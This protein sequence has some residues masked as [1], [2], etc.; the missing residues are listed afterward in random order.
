MPTKDEQ[1]RRSGFR[2]VPS[3]SMSSSFSLIDVF[4]FLFCSRFRAF[5]FFLS[6][7]RSLL[8]VRPFVVIRISLPFSLLFP[9]FPSSSSFFPPPADPTLPKLFDNSSSICSSG[10]GVRGGGRGRKK[11][12][13][14]GLDHDF[15]E[16]SQAWNSPMLKKPALSK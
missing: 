3:I 13:G 9:P 8:P 16:R 11:E 5:C 12:E 7:F 4:R 10:A 2:R 14:K 15:L 6:L 1:R